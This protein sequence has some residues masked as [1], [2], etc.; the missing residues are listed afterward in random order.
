MKL[1]NWYAGLGA[2]V[3]V[4][5]VPV[6]NSAPVRA[7]LEQA[8][9]A[10]TQVFNR[11]VVELNL[12]AALKTI[13]MDGQGKEVV[14]YENL[15]NKAS[16]KPGDV[17]LYSVEGTN[18]GDKVA[19]NLTLNQPIPDK[20]VYVLGSAK[21]NGAVTT[22][23]IDKGQTFV[24]NPTIKETSADGTVKEVPAPAEMYTHIRF[25]FGS[26]LAPEAGV[27]ANY[28]VRVR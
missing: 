13:S 18:A 16:V 26:E 2:L 24:A 15:G 14:S 19:Q 3:L 11:P 5:A 1:K 7:S 6:I 27:K 10:I 9:S 20:M 8:G 4:A 23:S 12:S 22:Y 25:E 28:E 21:A 17:L